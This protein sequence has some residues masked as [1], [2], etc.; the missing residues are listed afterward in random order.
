MVDEKKYL[1]EFN[2][3]L[4]AKSLISDR[5]D[6]DDIEKYSKEQL[7]E[8]AFHERVTHYYNWSWM[9]ERLTHFEDYGIRT[10]ALVHFDIKDFKM[11]NEIYGHTVADDVL[12]KVCQTMEKCSWAYF[13]CRCD[14]DNFAMM[15]EYDEEEVIRDRLMEM[16][17]KM[18]RLDVDEKYTVF[19]R[20]GVAYISDV[21][22]YRVI[23]TDMAKLAQRRGNNANATDINFYTDTMKD[24][25]IKG[26][27]IK[28]D[29]PRALANNELLVYFQPKYNPQN[30]E[31]V[32]AEALIRWN[33]H[34]EELW[35]PGRFVP[36]LEN[37]GSIEL[38][39]YFVLEE[40][41]RQLETWKKENKK[42]IPISVN[43][44]KIL[45]RNQNVINKIMDTVSKYD[46]DTSMIEF[47]ITE[48]MAYDDQKYMLYIMEELRKC[49]FQ[50]SLDDFGTG[51]SS[52]NMLSV[53]PITTLKIDKSFV[54]EIE[55]PLDEKTK[56]IIQD[57][58]SMSKHLNIKSVAEGV[59]TENQKNLIK[60]WGC[61]S[62]QGYFY[63]K[64]LPVEEFEKLL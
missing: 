21:E 31:I 39:D 60:S 35:A 43:M 26:K 18:N 25:Q 63:S 28:N 6:N 4:S 5:N 10:F 13:S 36:Y 19:F 29:L 61:N 32:G 62:I 20:C 9:R 8:L 27:L 45:L 34:H 37:E 3:S 49:G 22:N 51:Y 41:C 38:I 59:E 17:S 52:L 44:S 30:D 2:K 16:F 47:E 14:N 23:I 42:I 12:R 64:P 55:N 46:V 24:D 58:L 57:V 53:M 15:I 7:Y 50:L 48:T 40:T 56:L 54:D 11:I 1:N 33:Y